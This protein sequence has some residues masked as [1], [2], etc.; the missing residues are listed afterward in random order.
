MPSLEQKELFLSSLKEEIHYFQRNQPFAEQPF[1]TIYF[2]GGTPSLLTA[3]EFDPILKKLFACFSLK[4]NIEVTCEAN[5]GTRT[6]DE[7]VNYRKVGINRLSIGFQSLNNRELSSLSR[8]HNAKD[9]ILF[10]QNARSAGF[11]NLG[12]DLIYGIPGQTLAAWKQTVEKCLELR[13]DHFSAYSLTYEEGTPLKQALLRNK[14]KKCDEKLESEM[15]TNMQKWLQDA[16][17]EHY[18]I[19]NFALPGFRSQH[20]Q[21]YWD[22]SPYL[23]LG[24]SAHSFNGSKRWWNM[25]DVDE[26]CGRNQDGHSS[27]SGEEI[28]DREKSLIE[29]LMLGLRRKE[30]MDVNKWDKLSGKPFLINALKVVEEM[31]GFDLAAKPFGLSQKNQFLTLE[32]NAVCLTQQGL[33]LYDTVCKK[34]TE[35]LITN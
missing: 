32:N 25:A 18:E 10:F 17:Y 9:A 23:G 11:E 26:Y 1:S 6:R 4:N 16:G 24:P 8:I 31:G 12:I 19:S 3:E 28:I 22:G 21:K 13:P 27:I 30:G 29:L 20:N 35:Q 5:P 34:L 15:F 2:G 14:I 33:L 7:L